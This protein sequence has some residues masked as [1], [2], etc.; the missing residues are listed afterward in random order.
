MQDRAGHGQPSLRG[1]G[2]LK[3]FYPHL[4]TDHLADAAA[5][6]Q[7]AAQTAQGLFLGRLL[8]ETQLHLFE[9]LFPLVHLEKGHDRPVLI[10]PLQGVHLLGRL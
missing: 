5:H 6:A 4:F 7:V 2:Q 9:R 10:G 8:N 1:L 3:A